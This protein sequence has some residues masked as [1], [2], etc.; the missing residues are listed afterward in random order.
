MHFKNKRKAQG[1][2]VSESWSVQVS[3][4]VPWDLHLRATGLSGT[5]GG[6][7]VDQLF[8]PRSPTTVTEAFRLK[9]QSV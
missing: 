9:R 8:A 1:R 3:L 7:P 6:K 2:L 5:C 4:P